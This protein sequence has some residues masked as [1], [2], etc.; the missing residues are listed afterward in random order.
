MTSQIM[1]SYLKGIKLMGELNIA[2]IINANDPQ[3]ILCFA[4]LMRTDENFKFSGII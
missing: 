3:K 4:E 1:T 2:E